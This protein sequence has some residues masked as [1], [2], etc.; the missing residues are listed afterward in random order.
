MNDS[1]VILF[2]G[3]CNLCTASVQFVIRHDKKDIF[4]FASLQSAYGEKILGQNPEIAGLDSFLLK[5]NNRVYS[6][7]TAA[8]KVAKKLGGA[9]PL[10]YAFIIIPPFIR[11]AVYDWISANRYRW[12]GKK[13]ECWVATPELKERFLG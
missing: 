4:K 10:L 5:E 9:W 2:D 7:S 3:V 11:N 8:L 6:R 12:F 1:P 13:G